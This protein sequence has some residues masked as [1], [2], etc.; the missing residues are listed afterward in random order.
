MTA[1]KLH[2]NEV[3]IDVELVHQLLVTQF[4]SWSA[5]PL[6]EVRSTG[7]VNAIYRLGDDLY[8]RLPRVQAFAGDLE[9][10]LRWLPTLAPR[11]PLAVPEPGATG[12]P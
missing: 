4:P 7:T 1:K 8:V 2:D 12:E 11:L 6:D 9:K 10:E 3:D 5:L